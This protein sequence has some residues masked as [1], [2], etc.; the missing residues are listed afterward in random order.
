MLIVS[1]VCLYSGCRERTDSFRRKPGRSEEVEQN[2]DGKR[3]AS[4]PHATNPLDL[5]IKQQ[6]FQKL[7][8]MKAAAKCPRVIFKLVS[9]DDI[10][11]KCLC[12]CL[13]LELLREF[14]SSVFFNK[15]IL[16]VVFFK[17]N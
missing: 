4:Y 1:G 5:E 12:S 8:E 7:R 13:S 14:Y 6:F 16:T 10:R 2:D 17:Q 9:N 11:Q 15:D 3:G